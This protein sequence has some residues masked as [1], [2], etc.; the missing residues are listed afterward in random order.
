MLRSSVLR[1][2]FIC[3]SILIFGCS[4][5]DDPVTPQPYKPAELDGTLGAAGGTLTSDDGR[6]SITIPPGALGAETDLSITEIDLADIHPAFGDYAARA[7]L[8]LEPADLNLTA[9]AEISFS[10]LVPARPP[11][12]SK[13]D[14]PDRYDILIG[15]CETAAGNLVPDQ[16][17]EYD[18]DPATE[19]NFK[20]TFESTGWSQFAIGNSSAGGVKDGDDEFGKFFGAVFG[21]GDDAP[22]PLIKDSPIP[23]E[24]KIDL[25]IRKVAGIRDAFH[26]PSRY[27]LGWET[28]F[29]TGD[30]W[31]LG[32]I[33]DL[34]ENRCRYRYDI[35]LTPKVEGLL[36]YD[37]GLKV[38]FVI[39]DPSAWHLPLPDDPDLGRIDLTIFTA[40]REVM[41]VLPDPVEPVLTITTGM[42][43]LEGL[44]VAYESDDDPAPLGTPTDPWLFVTGST[45]VQYHRLVKNQ[46]RLI[47]STEL[48]NSIAVTGAHGVLPIS[49]GSGV[50]MEY[51]LFMYG[52]EF[53]WTTYW[54]PDVDDFGMLLMGY[55]TH[56]YD[57]VAY[58]DNAYSPGFSTA[59]GGAAHFSEYDAEWGLYMG[60]PGGSGTLWAHLFPDL[61]DPMV[62]C[63]VQPVRRS[64]LVLTSNGQIWFHERQD[65]E[66]NAVV[67]GQAQNDPRQ[68]RGADWVYAISNHGSNS[69][70]TFQWGGFNSINF[71]G[72]V[73]VGAGPHGIDA[74]KLS[75]GTVLVVSTS[76]TDNTY[77][78]SQLNTSSMH[79]KSKTF[80]MPASGQGPKHGIFVGDNNILYVALSCHDSGT[81][82]IIRVDMTDWL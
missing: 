22:S 53:N 12:T 32:E 74:V 3:L 75:D 27:S 73:S 26:G 63:F 6:L 66:V 68:I 78:L 18:F 15:I 30:P 47:V 64:A 43:G 10:L 36:T 67:V 80:T 21:P 56:L 45:G 31:D 37:A 35:D 61:V 48:V 5:S 28:G 41:V 23:F 54:N 57:A 33:E 17:I 76:A 42:T 79:I 77:T 19:Q 38:E 50:L 9:P 40:P 71:V 24:Y 2:F 60:Q 13:V 20:I 49:T 16:Q 8:E 34:P 70:T 72:T 11:G 59:R 62:S 52:P 4:T 82:E 65:I 25:P 14:D 69:L 46:D 7:V 29:E 81:V 1:L 39:V 55:N 58:G 44:N 51:C